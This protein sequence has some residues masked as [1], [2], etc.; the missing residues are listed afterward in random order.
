MCIRHDVLHRIDN[1]Q[2]PNDEPK[3]ALFGLIRSHQAH[4]QESHRDLA[5]AVAEGAERL[6][7]LQVH[8][9]F[10]EPGGVLEQRGDVSSDSIVDLQGVD[11]TSCN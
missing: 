7:E 1:Q 9:C 6:A 4:E 8:E 10:L 2:K 11:D 3:K 5:K